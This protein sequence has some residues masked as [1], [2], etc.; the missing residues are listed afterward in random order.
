MAIRVIEN[1]DGSY[2]FETSDG[3][4]QPGPAEACHLISLHN[5]DKAIVFRRMELVC[6]D[7]YG[8]VREQAT[9]SVACDRAKAEADHW[10]RTAKRQPRSRREVR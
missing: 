1:R 6:Q 7:G 3:D 5:L 9:N 8:S 2:Q 10:H 4:E